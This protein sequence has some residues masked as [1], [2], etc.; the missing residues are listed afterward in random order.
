MKVSIIQTNNVVGFKGVPEF[1]VIKGERANGGYPI[2][3]EGKDWER[4]T[5]ENLTLDEARKIANLLNK[6]K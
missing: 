3:I 4:L 1:M 2:G 6:T 5:R